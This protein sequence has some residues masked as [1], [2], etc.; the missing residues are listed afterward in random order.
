MFR[1]V[2]L[3]LALLALPALAGCSALGSERHSGRTL[4]V[5]S[6]Y[7]L[8]YVAQRIT[9]NHADVVNLTH[10]GQEP[11]DL[12]LDIR[13]TAD[14]V[15]ADVVV[16]E[17]GF[18]AAVDDAVDQSDPAHVVD[19]A[20]SAHLSGDDPHFW[21]DPTRLSAAA[22]AVEQQLAAAD[23]KHARDYA[24]NLEG[25][26]RELADLDAAYQHGLA[27]CRTRTIV[28]SH[29]AFGY[30]GRRYDLDVVAINGLSPDAEPSP[31]H[32]RQ[33]HDLVQ[34]DGITTVF[35]E[36]LASP[37]LADSLAG[38]LGIRTAVL[39]PVEGLSD[40]TADQDYLSLMRRN[41][42]HLREA[43]DCS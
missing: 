38:D 43:N 30:L 3:L 28:V 14:L 5:T 32:L 6:F 37:E 24:R 12:E 26:Q 20:D 23:P 25:L 1:R 7:P 16:Y 9:G 31:A 13:Q 29:D 11:H 22:G 18:Q 39:D 10:P 27:R 33:L 40:A 35:S 2:A 15:D 41:L 34:R 8:Q 42:S 36:E 19:V 21:L 17:R 4:V